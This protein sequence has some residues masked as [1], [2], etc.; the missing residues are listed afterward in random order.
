[1]K[2]TSKGVYT[3]YNH[4]ALHEPLAAVRSGHLNQ[5][6]ASKRF[7]ISH[8]TLRNKITGRCEGG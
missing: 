8:A 1:M 7:K 6:V 5:C 4:A 3:R 2:K